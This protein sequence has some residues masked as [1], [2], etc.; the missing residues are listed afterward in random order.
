MAALGALPVVALVAVGLT[1][2][3]PVVGSGRVFSQSA[4]AF[5]VRSI[6]AFFHFV[7]DAV[8]LAM[9]GSTRLIVVISVSSCRI[10][11]NWPAFYTATLSLSPSARITLSTVL[12]SGLPSDESAL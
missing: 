2:G 12:N 11:S 1:D 3:L 9:V 6:P 4:R 8:H 5:L 7:A 10:D